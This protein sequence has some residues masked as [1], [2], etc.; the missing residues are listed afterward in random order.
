MIR[1]ITPAALVT[2]LAGNGFQGLANGT[3]T[4]AGFSNPNAVAVDK[5]GNVYVADRLDYVIRKITPAGVVTTFAGSGAKSS[6]DGQGTTA[7]FNYPVGLAVDANDNVYVADAGANKIR[8]ITPTGLVS[9]YAGSGTQGS[10]DGPSA[11]AGFNYPAG[12][13]FDASGN[14][15][16]ADQNNNKIRKISAAGTVTTIAGS[17]MTG[18]TDGGGLLATF[19]AP[20]SVTINSQ[21]DLFVGDSFNYV[22]RKIVIG[23]G[24]SIDKLLPAGLVFDPA[25]GIISG[26]PTTASPPTN[27]TVTAY[28]AI[29]NSSAVINIT[30]N[31]PLPASLPAAPNISY[32]TPN[33]YAFG[34]AISPLAPTNTGGAVP[35]TIY[36]QVSTFAGSGAIGSAN[37]TGTVAS[38]NHPTRSVFDASGNLF[39]VD[40]DNNLIREITPAGVVTTYAGSGAQGATNGAA[41][42]ASFNQANG[43]AID[44]SGNLYITDAANNLIRMIAPGG[45]VSTFAGDGSPALVNGTG[46]AA[47]FYFPY[48]DCTDAAGNIYVADTFN[49]VIRKI[50]PARVV[51]TYAGSGIAGFNNGSK[52]TATFNNP[53]SIYMD[54]SG[55]MYVSDPNNHA[56]RKIDASGN[57]STLAGGTLGSADGTGTAASF[58]ATGGVTMDAI[59]DLYVA[60][61]GNNLIRKITAAGVVTT[62]AGTGVAGA[63][64]GI[65]TAASFNRPNDV[66]A[67]AGNLYVTDYGNNMIRKIILT[68]YT[69]DKALPAGLTFDP[70]TGIISGTP[71][72][73]WPPTVYTVTA[74]NTGGS[75][76]TPVSIEVDAAGVNFNPLPA[77]TICDADFDPGATSPF[78]I[79]Y[80]SSNLAVATIVGGKVHIVGAGTTLIT[81]TISTGSTKQ[82]LTVTAPA[83]PVVTI[84]PDFNAICTGMA[85]TYNATVTNG[86]TNPVYQWQLNGGNVG[87]NSATY[88][89]NTIAATDNVQCVVTNNDTCPVSGTSNKFTGIIVTA[90]TTPTIVIT[91]SATGAVC[92]GTPITFTAAITNGGTNPTYQW[93]VN[94]VSVG[95][96][97]PTFTSSSFNN[98][99]MVMCRLTNQGGACLTTLFA[100]SNTITVNIIAAPSPLPTVAI[101]ASANNVIIGT[102]ITFTATTTNATG[103]IISYQWLVNGKNE[104][105]NAPTFTTSS[106][107][108]GDVVTCQ[109]TVVFTCS[110]TVLSQQIVAVILGIPPLII[111]NTF[112]PN[113]DSVNDTWNIVNLIYYPNATVLIYNRYGALLY[114]SKGY[115]VQWDGTYNGQPVPVGTYQYLIDIGDGGKRSGSVAVIR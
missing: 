16:V 80:S 14:L 110:I 30:I 70:T 55:N 91:S 67:L 112:T 39:V 102:S 68:G 25:T 43:I 81:A 59:G 71:T 42:T 74:Y 72:V 54:N 6:N 57:V 64:N 23:A 28:N 75:S 31:H 85:V 105:K 98:G 22:I 84:S 33:V 95:S 65:R 53:N 90:Y 56:I 27:Y 94:S 93:T 5:A 1:K 89:T 20:S 108:N 82:T 40:R 86:G 38:F 88:T 66:V 61:L 113:G 47:S 78:P 58:G 83:I 69:I 41:G 32:H 103:G 79:T 9:T 100:T 21:G 115:S 37:G 13:V 50:T 77:K 99:D 4:A 106:L 8:K 17:G 51:T 92:L 35:A 96:N 63:V 111:P 34:T 24:Y 10:A 44:A 48:G 104:G 46:T 26:T 18:K 7:S 87:T 109:A 62:L 73:L 107:I 49:N 60:D 29:G 52:L 114:Q 97:S 101:T 45:T 76:S 36:G 12:L 3:G 11:T 2:T 15:Y 19:N